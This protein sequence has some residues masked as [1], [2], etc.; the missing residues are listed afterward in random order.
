MSTTCSIKAGQ[1]AL[2]D[3]E[4]AEL[5][6]LLVVLRSHYSHSQAAHTLKLSHHYIEAGA[7]RPS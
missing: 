2:T 5:E 4:T 7:S 1:A 6:W 3:L